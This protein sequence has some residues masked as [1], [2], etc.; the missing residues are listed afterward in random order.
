M[1]GTWWVYMIECR[2]GKI[3]TGIAKDPEA[4]YR[5]HRSGR[6][7]AFTRINPPVA[8]LA[9]RACGS[10]SDA[11]REENA[12]RRLSGKEKRAWARTFLNTGGRGKTE[13]RKDS[14]RPGVRCSKGE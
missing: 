2:G 8:L 14:S 10:R 12:L 3:Y 13:N 4:R 5:Q 1:S 9:K 7:A 6:G 11:L